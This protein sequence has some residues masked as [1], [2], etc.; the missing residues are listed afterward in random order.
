MLFMY[1]EIKQGYLAQKHAQ[2]VVK[3]LKLLLA[4][5]DE[6]KMATYSTCF[7]MAIVFLGKKEA[8]AQLPLL[9]ISGY[10][11]G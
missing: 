5:G 6:S 3:N 1:Q 7:E 10:I 11:L 8:V 4:G 2:V 9:T